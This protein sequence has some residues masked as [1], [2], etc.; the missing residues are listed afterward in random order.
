MTREADVP[1]LSGGDAAEEKRG[2][3]GVVNTIDVLSAF[4]AGE[5]ALGVNEIARR[6]GLHKSSVSRIL[7][8]LERARFVEKVQESGKYRLGPGLIALTGRMLSSL[9]IIDLARPAMRSL[10]DET[11][12]TVN[13]SILN[14]IEVLVVDQIV[15]S[16][17]INIVP[18]GRSPT[19]C[20]ATGRA[21]L[22]FSPAELQERALTGVLA[23]VTHSTVT[24]RAAIKKD[25]QKIVTDRVSLVVNEFLANAGAIASPILDSRGIPIGAISISFAAFATDAARIEFLKSRILSAAIQISRLAGGV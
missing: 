22:A 16:S 4:T 24:D 14:G 1:D 8:A 12:E 6:V 2:P 19:Y 23:P 7:G 9:G 5:P 17:H 13:L 20:T 21:L 11:G 10:A 25:L 15:G 3:S 18:P